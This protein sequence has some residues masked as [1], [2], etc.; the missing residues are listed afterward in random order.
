MPFHQQPAFALHSQTQSY[1][2]SPLHFFASTSSSI[3][4]D[5]PS[6]PLRLAKST[7][8]SRLLNPGY[9]SGFILPSRQLSRAANEG[10]AGCGPH[11]GALQKNEVGWMKTTFK[12]SYGHPL[13]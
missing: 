2:S 1:L 11:K 6:V 10:W 4:T 8:T 9:S 5:P 13:W 7:M 12:K 3:H